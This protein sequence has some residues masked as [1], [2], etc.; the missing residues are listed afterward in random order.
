MSK[1]TYIT[2]PKGDHSDWGHCEEQSLELGRAHMV[3]FVVG[4]TK[5]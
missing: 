2:Q 4:V 1:A 3:T 5:K